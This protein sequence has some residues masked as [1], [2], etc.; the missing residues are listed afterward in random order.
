MGKLLF[1]RIAAAVAPRLPVWLAYALAWLGGELAYRFA[2]G[3]RRAVTE[4]LR[5]VL[6][7]QGSPAALQRA[8]RGV[9]RTATYNYLDLFLLPAATPTRLAEQVEILHPERFFEVYQRGKGVIITTAHL[10]NFDLVVQLSERY[11]VPVSILV[12]PLEPKALFQLV[13]DLRGSHGLKLVPVGRRGLGVVLRTLREG[14]VVAIA[15]DRDIQRRGLPVVFFGEP[16][17]LPQGAIELA[18]RT[19]AAVVPAFGLRLPGRRYQISLEPP[20]EI[21]EDTTEAVTKSLQRLATILERYIGAH[22]EQWVVFEPLW[23]QKGLDKAE[24]RPAASEAVTA[25][26]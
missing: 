1:Y 14:G 3:P 15:A 6:G 12:E 25:G 19:G 22:P 13:S 16:T 23:E 17:R 10:G 11:N 9:F 18:L 20:L 5:R 7:L 21:G 8:V 26:R 24:D 4:N 2:A